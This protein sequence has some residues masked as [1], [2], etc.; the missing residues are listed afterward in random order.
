MRTELRMKI[1][2]R[3]QHCDLIYIFDTTEFCTHRNTNNLSKY[4]R[5][6]K[7]NIAKSSVRVC[8]RVWV[9]RKND[10]IFDGAFCA[11]FMRFNAIS[12]ELYNNN[13]RDDDHHDQKILIK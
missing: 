9:E 4:D 1:S 7:C 5:K 13:N 10:A 3:K 12:F 8:A 2:G 6:N 11:K